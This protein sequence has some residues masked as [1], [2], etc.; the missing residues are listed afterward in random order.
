MRYTAKASTQ[1]KNDRK[2][3]VKYLSQ[4]SV[5]A[6]IKFKQELKKHIDFVTSTPNMFSRWD[7]NPDYRHVVIFGSY[8]MFYTVDEASKI[9]FIYRILH[10]SQDIANIL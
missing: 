2:R 4:F 6:P 9:V 10:G 1:A 3:I 7:S 8:V 5:N